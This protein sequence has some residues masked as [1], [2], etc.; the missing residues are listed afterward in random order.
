MRALAL[1]AVVAAA[2]AAA[3]CGSSGQSSADQAKS[4]AC[5]AYSDIGTQLT[6]LQGV[7]SGATSPTDAQAALTA[8]SNDLTTIRTEVPNMTGQLKT[9]LQT[10]NTTFKADVQSVVNNVTSAGSLTGA[11]TALNQAAGQL[12]TSYKQAFSGVKC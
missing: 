7:S 6:K 11:A 5:T 1:V 8:I 12:S 4:K 2:L 10:A 3:G 9:Q